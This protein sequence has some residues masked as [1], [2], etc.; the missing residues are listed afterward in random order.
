M[1]AAFVVVLCLLLAVPCLAAIPCDTDDNGRLSEGEMVGAIFSYLDVTYRNGTGTAPSPADLQDA[2]FIYHHW[3]GTPG[4]CT[5]ATGRTFVF[6]RPIRAVAVM[7]S[8]TLETIRAIGYPMG[9]VRGAEHSILMDR[10]FF[11]DL[12]GCR[13][14]GSLDEPD[15]AALVSLFPDVVFAPAGP[16]G[17]LAAATAS[18]LGIPVLRFSCTAPASIRGEAL[19]IGSL[20]GCQDGAEDLCRF[21][22]E[23]D[24]AVRACFDD[25]PADQV[26]AVYVESFPAYIACG[27]GTPAG[28]L[29]LL[30]GGSPVP[31]GSG[32]IGVDDGMVIAA[33]PAV[34][35]KLVGEDPSRFGGFGDR[36]PLRF[37]EVR[38][39]IGNR[40]GWSALP[41]ERE[42]RVYLI[43]ASLVEGPRYVVGL[44]YSARWLHPDRCAG[45]DPAAVHE[46]YLSRFCGLSGVSGTFVYPGDA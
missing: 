37:I 30:G 4:E 43:H 35:I 36:L 3:G 44:H 42:E 26:R 5:D 38:N 17:D 2:S 29:V 46:E 34:V 14:V 41:A 21:L 24:E 20:L 32:M 16:E 13:A 12:V 23:Q 11:P 22:D 6:E 28:D 10:Q 1:K 7:S 31:A 40:P 27:A 9:Y 18:A 19:A 33:A 39:A 15:A 45:L 8:Q 25:L